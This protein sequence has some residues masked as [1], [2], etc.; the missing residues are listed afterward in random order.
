MQDPLNARAVLKTYGISPKKKLGQNF[1]IRESALDQVIAAAGLSKTV[2]I[3]EIGA[4]LGALTLSLAKQHHK[5]VAIEYDQR[6][7]PILKNVL[8]SYEN[9]SILQGDFLQLQLEDVITP[10]EYFVVANI[11]YQI[12]SAVIRKVVEAPYPARRIVLT[13]QKEVAER[14]IAQP[15]SLSLLALSVQ[16]FGK[17]RIFSDIAS[18]A[19]YPQPKVQSSVLR[20]D[21]YTQPLIPM[22]EIDH[23]F[24]IAKMG[25]AQKRKK[26]RNA[27]SAGLHITPAEVEEIMGKAKIKPSMRAQEL[28]IDQWQQLSRSFIGILKGEGTRRVL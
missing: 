5:V 11:P 1:I 14:I 2:Q 23:F 19:F 7:I 16:I 24:R 10:P 9:V 22:Q 8:G 17:P 12:T 3:L 26:L 21:M 20:V 18:K 13:I 27:L 15:G 25:F 28:A 4:G 6:L